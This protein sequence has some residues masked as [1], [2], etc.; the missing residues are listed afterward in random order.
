MEKLFGYPIKKT[1]VLMFPSYFLTVCMQH[2]NIMKEGIF[3]YSLVKNWTKKF[4]GKLKKLDAIIF[5]SNE[6]RMHW[7]TF[8][9][10]PQA[11][12]IEAYDSLGGDGIDEMKAL[13][14]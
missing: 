7:W 14:K 4:D 10:Y 2:G 6:K 3:E 8:A 5:I 11:Q 9:I 1:K 12:T 13:W